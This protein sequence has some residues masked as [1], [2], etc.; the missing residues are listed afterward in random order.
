[1]KLADILIESQPNEL[2]KLADE[3]EAAGPQVLSFF[4]EQ[5]KPKQPAPAK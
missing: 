1:M 3:I 5:L 2:Q 4:I